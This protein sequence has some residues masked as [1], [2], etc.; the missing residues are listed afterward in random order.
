MWPFSKKKEGAAEAGE[1]KPKSGPEVYHGMRE[2]ALKTKPEDIGLNAKPGEPYG[3]LMDLATSSGSA[4]LMTM[5]EGS[6]SIYYSGGGGLLGGVGHDSVRNAGLALIAAAG[7][8]LTL[9]QTTQSFPLPKQNH[10]RFYVLTPEAVHTYEANWDALGNNHD[11][12]S[13]LFHLG[14]NVITQFR[15]VSE[16]QGHG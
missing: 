15:L 1:A 8:Y 2:F 13:P 5:C 14:D 3:V 4:T 9:M 7:D 16:K 6:V 12:L 10:V 11:P